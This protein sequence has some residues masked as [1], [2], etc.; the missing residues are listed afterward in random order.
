VKPEKIV[1]HTTDSIELKR[2]PDKVSYMSVL[3]AFKDNFALFFE[4]SLKKKIQTRGEITYYFEISQ[5][6]TVKDKMNL[7]F[8][9][10][11]EN[12]NNPEFVD[13]KYNVAMKMGLS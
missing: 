8:D 6:T 1:L 2:L 7:I 10:I 3:R 12:F 5:N 9:A 4:D 11:E 13:E